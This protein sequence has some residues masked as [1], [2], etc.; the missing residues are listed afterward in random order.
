MTR[1]EKQEQAL[2]RREV[3]HQ[4]FMDFLRAK[5]QL[6]LDHGEAS[7]LSIMKAVK[8]LD[9]HVALKIREKP[10]EG[11]FIRSVVRDIAID[12]REKLSQGSWQ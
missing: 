8:A 4:D 6:C 5:Y 2:K 9:D 7:S 3:L 10:Q 12:M 1:K 11:E